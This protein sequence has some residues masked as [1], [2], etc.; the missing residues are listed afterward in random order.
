MPEGRPPKWEE[1]DHSR[2]IT[3]LP[4][5][6][7]DPPIPLDW[8]TR[9]PLSWDPAEP[10]S[11]NR[12]H[13]EGGGDSGLIKN[14]IPL[15]WDVSQPL[16]WNQ[17]YPEGGGDS[18]LIKDSIPLSWDVAKPFSWYGFTAWFRCQSML[19]PPGTKN[20]LAAEATAVSS[21]TPFP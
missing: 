7:I 3:R 1:V 20:T 5:P 13:P 18:G 14:S 10:L 11:W 15:S 2:S 16:S 19:T 6:M 4:A 8:D 12:E 21:K 9:Q 17:Q